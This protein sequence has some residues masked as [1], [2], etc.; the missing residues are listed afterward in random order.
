VKWVFA[1][2]TLTATLLLL[3]MGYEFYADTSLGGMPRK[4]LDIRLSRRDRGAV[5]GAIRIFAR[6]HE[7]DIDEMHD[8]R[9]YMP[10]DSFELSKWDAEIWIFTLPADDSAPGHFRADPEHFDASVAFKGWLWWTDLKQADGYAVSLEAH[11]KG[12]DRDAKIS[13]TTIAPPYPVAP[14]SASGA[15]KKVLN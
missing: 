9:R 1:V 4:D 5:F 8:D 7:F 14:A 15:A 10:S 2:V 12:A 13:V 3:V 6:E 11:I